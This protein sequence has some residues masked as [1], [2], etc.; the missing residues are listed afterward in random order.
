MSWEARPPLQPR[1]HCPSALSR[2]SLLLWHLPPGRAR[3]GFCWL[4]LRSHPTPAIEVSTR[5]PL[6]HWGQG[7]GTSLP[8]TSTLGLGMSFPSRGWRPGTRCP[9]P[10]AGTA[11]PP[12]H[13]GGKWEV[14]RS[15]HPSPSPPLA[16][17]RRGKQ[18]RGAVTVLNPPLHHL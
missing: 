18:P 6:C 17:H 14:P 1:C 11:R 7:T 10:P 12:V 15:R 16:S 4:W 3:A 8:C 2:R 9:A 5:C 13:A